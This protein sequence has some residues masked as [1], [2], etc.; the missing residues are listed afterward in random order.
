MAGF[1]SKK[2]Y[3]AIADRALAIKL[4]NERCLEC[5]NEKFWEQYGGIVIGRIQK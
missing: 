2:Q 1:F 3:G 5:L 4:L